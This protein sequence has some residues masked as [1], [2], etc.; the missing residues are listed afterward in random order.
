MGD[1]NPLALLRHW[2]KFRR[3]VTISI[4]IAMFVLAIK[5]TGKTLKN[6]KC[7]VVYPDGIVKNDFKNS[8]FMEHYIEI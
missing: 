1:F 8:V 5:R 2:M 3:T 7:L 4:N 6:D